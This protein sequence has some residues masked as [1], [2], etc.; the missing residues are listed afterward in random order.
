MAAEVALS[1]VLLVGAGLMVRTLAWL[2]GLNPGFDTRNVIAAEA[3]L[4]DARYQTA[5]AVD[6]LYT[7]T[8]ERMRRIPGVQSAAV[9][10]TLPYERPLNNGFRTVDGDDHDAHM[11]EFVYSTPTY[12]E[13]MHIPVV[14]GR[15]FRDSDTSQRTHVVVVSESFAR[16]YF[17]GDALGRHLR[18]GK[19]IS[20]IV[21]VC[22]DVQQHSGLGS[23]EGPLSIEPTVYL[24]ASQLNDGFVKLI[25][26][27]F[28]PKW[29]I[30]TSGPAANLTGQIRAAV[31]ATD[32]QLPV[33]RFRTVDELRGRYTGSQRYLAALFSILA[34]LALL[35]S[36][37]RVGNWGGTGDVA[38]RGA[39]PAEPAVGRARNGPGDVRGHR[40]NSA[41]GGGA[42]Q[43]GA[44]VKDS[45]DGP[46]RDAAE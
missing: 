28:S 18:S 3:S 24:P 32:P 22:G 2:N 4:Q 6:R 5:A 26:T 15:A 38:D 7:Q 37:R 33:A 23:D 36:A 41:I 25:H 46:G 13:T 20:E 45:A 29:V 11:G 1:L 14:A 8:L 43:P 19:E 16:R 35:N 40:R 21:G 27:W 17:H 39:I 44:R 42:G 10:L 9:A 30:R 34:G 12:F 31:S